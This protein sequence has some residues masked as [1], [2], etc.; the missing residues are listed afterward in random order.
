MPHPAVVLS[1]AGSDS[2][3]G[4]GIQADIKTISALGAYAATAVTALTAQNTLAVRAI[5]AP[6]HDFLREQLSAVLEDLQV[7]AIKIGMLHNEDVVE[8]V[9]ESL[10]GSVTRNIVLDPVM[11]AT[12]GSTLI[13][14]KTAERI[15]STLFPCA[16]LIT[17][18]LDEACYLLNRQILTVEDMP[19]A[20]MALQSLGARNVLLKG[21]HL[22]DAKGGPSEK[23]VDF[24]LTQDGRHHIFRQDRIDTK[25]THGTGCS[26]SAAIATYLAFGNDL[27]EAVRLA[28]TYVYQGLIG[29]RELRI[30][31]GAGPINHFFQP[32]AMRF[33]ST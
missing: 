18:N 13:T 6:P 30:G 29:A 26:L 32:A 16:S 3:G 25:N 1:I 33:L 23:I 19:A 24:L 20:A 9:H 4:A 8:A 12:S 22:L 31:Q 21:G 11:V 5:H 15:V 10:H 14:P 2:S 28:Q 27:P 7:A 17:P